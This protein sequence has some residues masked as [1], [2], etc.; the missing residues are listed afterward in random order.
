MEKVQGGVNLDT[1]CGLTVMGSIFFGALTGPVGA[2][3]GFGMGMINAYSMGCMGYVQPANNDS[4]IFTKNRRLLQSF[5]RQSAFIS[6][7]STSRQ[8]SLR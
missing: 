5:Y 2:V 8:D 7:S 1:A 3:A 6:G 4:D